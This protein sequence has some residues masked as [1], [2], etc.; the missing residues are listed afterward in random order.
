M[1]NKTRPTTVVERVR[2]GI[3]Q[4]D[5]NALTRA[6]IG[7]AVRLALIVFVVWIQFFRGRIAS[8]IQLRER[9]IFLA[10]RRAEWW[11]YLVVM[12][13]RSPALLLAMVVYWQALAAFGVD[14]VAARGL[15]PC[16]TRRHRR[17]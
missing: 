17:R 11:Q 6:K 15:A 5:S 8:G 7:V 10:F 16:P 2:D 1:T 14:A 12:L 9:D 4:E 13:L 3:A